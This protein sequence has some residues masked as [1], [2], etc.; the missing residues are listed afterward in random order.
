MEHE[1]RKIITKD[2][3]MPVLDYVGKAGELFYDVDSQVLRIS[4]GV[5]AGGQII[6]GGGFTNGSVSMPDVAHFASGGLTNYGRAQFGT[7]VY[8]SN[9]SITDSDY[10][11][12]EVYMGSGYGEF[13][14]IYNFDQGTRSALTYA[15]VE[16]TPNSYFSGIVS[17]TPE[18]DSMY[19]VG[20]NTQDNIILG[21]AQYLGSLKATGWA[22]ALG[23]FNARY[24]INGI[25]T[26][27][28]LVNISGGTVASSKLVLTDTGVKVVTQIDNY[29]GVNPGPYWINVY[30]NINMTSEYVS[31]TS[32]AYASDGSLYM[33]GYHH[34]NDHDDTLALKYDTSGNIVWR[35]DW[36]DADG[37]PCGSYNNVFAIDQAHNDLI[38]W[39]GAAANRQ[40]FGIN[41]RDG[42][43]LKIPLYAEGFQVR[44]MQLIDNT[45]N[46]CVVGTIYAANNSPAISIINFKDGS[47]SYNANLYIT[48]SRGDNTNIWNSVSLDAATGNIVT[49][50]TYTNSD[51][52]TRP[53]IKLWN[54]NGTP[55]TTYDVADGL[56]FT[57]DYDGVAAYYDNSH[58]YSTFIDHQ[59]GGSYVTKYNHSDL[60]TK[61][62][63]VKIGDN[64][65]THAYDLTFDSTGN[66]YV[67][68]T[69]AGYN[70]PTSDTD[71]FLWKLNHNT[72]AIIWNY[73]I[74]SQANEGNQIPEQQDLY[75]SCRGL[76]VYD[77][78]VAM[79]G[80][81]ETPASNPPFGVLTAVFT[82]Q[83][84]I[85]G[86][87]TST[88]FSGGVP[89]QGAFVTSWDLGYVKGNFANSVVITDTIYNYVLPLGNAALLATTNTFSPGNQEVHLDLVT[90]SIIQPPLRRNEWQF[91]VNGVI[92]LPQAGDIL[93][94]DG[95]SVIRD[96]IF[97]YSADLY[98]NS[99]VILDI[100]KDIHI[101][102][103]NS[104]YGYL[105]PNGTVDG[106]T[107]K[108]IA[109]VG[110]TDITQI[111][112][113]GYFAQISSNAVISSSINWNPFNNSTGLNTFNTA[114]WYNNAWYAIL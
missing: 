82:F 93:D 27:Q 51:S 49:M 71:F 74:G 44:D 83:L 25:Y 50:G 55:G 100:T 110:I 106:Q 104:S 68:G 2:G 17:Q 41:D 36:T 4:D 81:V 62:W 65:N 64:N 26:D 13:R 102:V 18:M 3:H 94:S 24:N 35:K 72:G 80:I 38:Y 23:T 108:L 56:D 45:G 109:D 95:R 6:S 97:P 86:S 31:G 87:V 75:A 8:Y 32:L 48:G 70:P 90:D 57:H 59:L 73:S 105:I 114:V 84:P 111:Q 89:G 34:N 76:A 103:D 43:N 67:G 16:D 101:L 15:G 12:S 39:V 69:S 9:T 20:T 11:D 19:T 33:F 52:R 14:S 79:T 47:N 112:V 40:Y 98:N 58:V 5:T 29:T 37:M 53:V 7:E 63:Q 66:V 96:S 42:N 22:T 61:L 88:N 107:V 78:L 28:S 46:V 60:T 113:N 30:G 91:D 10:V 54:I 77:D 85:D 92:H 1:L 99:A 21:A